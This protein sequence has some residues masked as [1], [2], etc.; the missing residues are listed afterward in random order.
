M[1]IVPQI[2]LRTYAHWS[3][4]T[5]FMALLLLLALTT[6]AV[7]GTIAYVKQRKALADQTFNQL[8]GITRTK[9]SQIEGYYQ[10]IHNHVS[11]LSSDRIFIDAIRD[12]KKAND[13]MNRATIQASVLNAVH[14]NYR[15]QFFPEMQRL[16]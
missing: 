5:K 7:C 6:L 13:K 10:T 9:R 3:I 15:D 11:T 4:R 8:T 12:F 14:D 2:K 1:A 16:H